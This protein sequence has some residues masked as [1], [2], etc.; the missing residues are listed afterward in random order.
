M[1]ALVLVIGGQLIRGGLG[2]IWLQVESGW[3]VSG[4]APLMHSH[5]R[6]NRVQYVVSFVR[7]ASSQWAIYAESTDLCKE[8]K[9]S[10]HLSYDRLFIF[11]T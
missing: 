4:R 2:K 3:R 5:L 6:L 1:A 8:D 10:R 11:S 9:N 7:E